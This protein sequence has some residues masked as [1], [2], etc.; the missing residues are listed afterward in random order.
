MRRVVAILILFVFALI[1]LFVGMA[2]NQERIREQALPPM[3]G[4]ITV[5]TDLPS[6]LTSILAE[7]YQNKAHI[8]VRM[9]SITDSQMWNKL[10]HKEAIK[11]ADLVVT[12][13]DNLMAG[14]KEGH[15][16][17]VI[18]PG[19]DEVASRFK[20]ADGYW[21]GI[22]YDPIVFAEN[23]T[24]Y[25]QVGKNI[26]TWTT[27]AK[28]GPW[29]IIMPDFVASTEAANILYAMVEVQGADHAIGYLAQ[30]RDHVVQYTKF[31][32]TPVR[33]AALGETD[34]GIGT[35]TDAE[36]YVQKKYPLV[37]IFPQDGTPYYLTGVALLQGAPDEEEAIQFMKWLGS[38]ETA[39]ILAKQGYYF[40]YT[41]PELP[42][43][44]D[45]LGRSPVLFPVNGGYTQEGKKELLNTWIVN[46]RFRKD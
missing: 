25:N 21:T 14:T 31:L 10:S 3:R 11:G 43:I 40:A 8:K 28:P 33:L 41:N 39:N 32:S 24:F 16:K 37:I 20:N 7:T 15:F 44:L 34:I 4:T 6:D 27:L 13:Q 23:K 36:Q 17:P 1:I 9:V 2:V 12:T 5:Y 22:W 35:Y 29:R 30:L 26:K 18:L 42:K 19:F 38:K 46:V 45:S